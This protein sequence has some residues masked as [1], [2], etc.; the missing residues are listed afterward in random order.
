MN[1]AALGAAW[2][3]RFVSHIQKTDTCWLWMG[4]RQPNGYGRV[5]VGRFLA[6]AH[7][8]SY[9]L[10]NG[11]VGPGLVLDHL[12]R[13]PR[14]VNPAHLEAVTHRTNTIRG[15]GPAGITHRT[16]RCVRGHVAEPGRDCLVCARDRKRTYR[17]AKRQ[18]VA[19]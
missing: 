19:S 6:M 10:A 8:V 3:L 1:V 16:G 4:A 9:A 11:D 7:R 18:A 14:C 12:C 2:A 15:A 5:K 17:A 13:N